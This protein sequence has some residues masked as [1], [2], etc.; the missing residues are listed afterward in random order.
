MATLNEPTFFYPK[1]PVRIIRAYM[2]NVWKPSTATCVSASTAFTDRSASK[3]KKKTI[4]NDVAL[5]QM[6]FNDDLFA[7]LPVVKCNKEEVTVPDKGRVS[8]TH[9]Y[10]EFSY[11]SSCQ[12]SCE[13][14]YELSM[15]RALRCTGSAKWSEPPPTCRCE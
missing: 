3:V 8:C 10:G 12:Y 7:L 6:V 11:N 9:S 14:G 1:L 15:T 5:S 4:H 13:Q 2:E